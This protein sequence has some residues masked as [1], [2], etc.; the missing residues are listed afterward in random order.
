MQGIYLDTDGSLLTALPNEVKA[1]LPWGVGVGGTTW[2]SAVNSQLLDPA[3]CVYVRGAH[4]SNNGALCNPALTFRW[5]ARRPGRLRA[6][7]AGDCNPLLELALCRVTRYRPCLHPFGVCDVVTFRPCRRVMLNS[8]TP[9]SIKFRD[10]LVTNETSQRTSIVKFSKYNE[11][12]YQFT[13]ATKR[14]YW[15]HWDQDVRVD[16]ETVRC[17][18]I[19]AQYRPWKHH[20]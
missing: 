15:L 12:G 4:T 11:Q 9:D 5:A 3:E 6:W 20:L 19:H 18:L 14:D 1:Q 17:G 7:S 10:L 2:H 8:H 16:P 13:V